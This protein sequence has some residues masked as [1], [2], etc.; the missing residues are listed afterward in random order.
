[1]MRTTSSLRTFLLGL[2]L[3]LGWNAVL[4]QDASLKETFTQAKALWENQGDRDNAWNRFAVVRDALEPKLRSLDPE[5]VQVLSETYYWMAVLKDRVQAERAQ[6]SKLLE[7]LLDLNPDFE[8]DKGLG[9]KRL[10]DQF[11]TLRSGKLCRVK[12][13]LDPEGGRLTVDG[14]VRT[15]AGLRFLPP[16]THSLAYTKPGYAPVEQQLDLVLKKEV[17]VELKLA[18]NSSVLMVYTSP[19]GAEVF[20]DGKLVGKTEGRAP[21]DQRAIA[22]RVG[23]SVEQLSAVLPV[24]DLS[25]GT[26][27]LEVRAAC[28]KTRKIKIPEDWT[29]PFVDQPLEP[30][31][32]EPSQ[33]ILNVKSP[34]SGEM[35]LSGKSHGTVPLKAAMI[36]AGTYDLLIKYP[37]GAYTRR[38]EIPEGK[39]I[40]VDARPKARLA[41]LGMDGTDDFAGKDAFL[42]RLGS[43]NEVLTEVAVIPPR[44]GEGVKDALGRLRTTKDAELVLYVRP[45]PGKPIQQLELVLSTLGDEEERY[46]VKPLAQDPMGPLVTRL[47]HAPELWEPWAGL[48]TLDVPG[49]SGPWLLQADDAALKS[50]LKAGKAIQKVNGKAVADSLALRKALREAAPA[51]K[52]TLTQAEGSFTVPITLWGREVPVLGASFSYPFLL[53]D[54]RL[55]A[56]GATGEE[57]GLLRLNQALVLMHY[58]SYD[59]ALEVLREA[60]LTAPAGVCGATLD[61]YAGFCLL[62]LG[63]AY[64]NEAIQA[65]NQALK[66][67]RATFFGPDGPLVAPLAKQALEELKP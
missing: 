63:G 64:T 44:P 40:E 54:L 66:N 28:Y 1:M 25:V 53:A 56:Q 22:E 26:H 2:S 9:T 36:C 10:Q 20:L 34:V 42:K 61:Y 38:L 62:R 4:A 52:A 16:G 30:V 29:T 35:L 19:V 5:W 55:R 43:L 17:P 13:V 18:R 39:T 7:S 58:R 21:E 3:L 33:G 46:L 32:L 57:L 12:L 27:F 15:A 65:F 41:Y 8:P 51:G 14:K 24:A 45:V 48:I 6:A 60:R 23:I 47:N 67:P 50:G 59:R 31:K 49:E 37:Q 11:D